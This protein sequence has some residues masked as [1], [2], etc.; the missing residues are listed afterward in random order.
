M[1]SIGCGTFL[2]GPVLYFA[3]PACLSGASSAV[4]GPDRSPR[5]LMTRNA[6]C[7]CLAAWLSFVAGSAFAQAPAPPSESQ[8]VDPPAHVAVVDGRASLE[9]DGRPEPSPLSM[10]LLAGDSLRTEDGRGGGVFAGGA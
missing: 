3:L 9:R 5:F 8:T 1:L 7:A 6:S 4:P 10:P 2:G